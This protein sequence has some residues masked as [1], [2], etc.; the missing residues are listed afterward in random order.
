MLVHHVLNNTVLALPQD[1]NV[2]LR[3]HFLLN[4]ITM[5]DYT[6]KKYHAQN[7]GVSLRLYCGE[8][9][10]KNNVYTIA[11]KLIYFEPSTEKWVSFNI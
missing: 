7:G 4:M 2:F 6:P 10:C 5:H 8:T 9:R 3:Y 1:L 11:I